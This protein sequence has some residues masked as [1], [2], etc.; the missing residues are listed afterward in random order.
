MNGNGVRKEMTNE[1]VSQ[2]LFCILKALIFKFEEG[3]REW[4]FTCL[5]CLTDINF[6]SIFS[7]L[8]NVDVPL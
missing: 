7:V 5:I 6:L 4:V 8:G 3:K 1:N 2:Q